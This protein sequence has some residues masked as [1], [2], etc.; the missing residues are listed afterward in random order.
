MKSSCFH[1]LWM[2]IPVITSC[3]TTNNYRTIK[4]ELLKPGLIATDSIRNIA[5]FNQNA[6]NND[7]DTFYF[8]DVTNKKMIKNS[9]VN[10]KDLSNTC[11]DAMADYLRQSGYFKSV[12]NYRDSIYNPAY[13]QNITQRQK[14]ENCINYDAC[15]FLENINLKDR[16]MTSSFDF[17]RRVIANFP[18]F[19]NSTIMETIGTSLLWSI[20]YKDDAPFQEY[21]RVDNLYYGNS[22]NF[23][24]FGSNENHKKLLKNTAVHLGKSFAEELVPHWQET[25]RLY[26][27]SHNPKMLMAQKQM[28]NENYRGAAELYR[29]MTNNKNH[30][31]AAKA[32]FNMALICEME[33]NLEAGIDWLTRSS[34]TANKF[35][36][37]HFIKCT[38]YI[39]ILKIRRKEIDILSRQVIN[40]DVQEV[41]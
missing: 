19:A 16:L 1:L 30:N 17:D 28:F 5:I 11:T 41:D 15:I 40:T 13:A 37:D 7:L 14:K 32:T 2:I 22:V 31:I 26:Y 34:N 10:Y 8:E 4:L 3:I 20:Y 39:N 6:T 29:Q 18:E 38:E 24:L 27:R 23:N 12:I 36:Y 21:K 35:N 9:L 33:G 25:E